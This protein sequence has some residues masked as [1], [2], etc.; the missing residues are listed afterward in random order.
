MP[1]SEHL[2]RTSVFK[3]GGKGNKGVELGDKR[4]ESLICA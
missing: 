1:M 3:V 4:S 2:R